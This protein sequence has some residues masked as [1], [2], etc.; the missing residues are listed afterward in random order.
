MSRANSLTTRQCFSAL[1]FGC[2]LENEHGYRVWLH[3]GKQVITNKNRKSRRKGRY[4]YKFDYP[5]WQ[6]VGEISTINKILN[7]IYI[8]WER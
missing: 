4:S 2:I 1:E 6:V 8:F 7:K 3:K 5:T